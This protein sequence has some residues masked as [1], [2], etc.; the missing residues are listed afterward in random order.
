M[1]HPKFPEKSPETSR[2]NNSAELMQIGDK[3][4]CQIDL[5]YEH[6]ILIYMAIVSVY[7]GVSSVI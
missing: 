4:V 6:D 2:L 7:I 5:I 1:E 3:N